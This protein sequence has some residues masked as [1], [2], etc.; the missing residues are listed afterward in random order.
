MKSIYVYENIKICKLAK[1]KIFQMCSNCVCVVFSFKK[2]IEI[3]KI[4]Q[5]FYKTEDF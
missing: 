5:T 1:C 3:K 2:S 4:F